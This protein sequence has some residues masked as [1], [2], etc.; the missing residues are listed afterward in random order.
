MT[1]CR[2]REMRAAVKRTRYRGVPGKLEISGTGIVH[3]LQ[4]PGRPHELTALRVR[5][6]LERV[7]PEEVA[8]HT[9]TPDVEHEPEGLLRHP[10]IMV[11]ALEDMEGEGSSDPRTVVAAIEIVSRSNPDNDWVGKT[12]DHPSLGI[13]VYAVFDPRTGSGAVFTDIHPTPE[14][15]RYATRKDFLY[16]EEVTIAGWTIPTADLPR[17]AP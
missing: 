1:V 8:A 10:D 12:W 6:R 4:A 13:P 5:G 11:I 7:L 17:Y 15:P 16:G 2:Y 9:G 14:G 3:D